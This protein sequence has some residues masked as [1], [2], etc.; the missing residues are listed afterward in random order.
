MDRIP[1]NRLSGF[2]NVVEKLGKSKLNKVFPHFFSIS[3]N[4]LM[5]FQSGAQRQRQI[6]ISMLKIIKK[7]E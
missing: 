5:M 1:E 2:G 4:F 6:K 7:M 3:G